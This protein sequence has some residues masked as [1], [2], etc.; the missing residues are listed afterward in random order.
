MK[1]WGQLVSSH[2]LSAEFVN[3]NANY[4]QI[5]LFAA[6]EPF[7]NAAASQFILGQQIPLPLWLSLAPVVLGKPFILLYFLAWS[8]SMWC[9]DSTQNISCKLLVRHV[10]I[11]PKEYF[12]YANE[13]SRTIFYIWS[14]FVTWI[15]IFNLNLLVISLI[16]ITPLNWYARCINGITNWA[17]FQLVG[18][19]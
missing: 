1:N 12:S 8:L 13:F 3:W 5:S 7:F 4:F 16:S 6:L 19:H 14:D 2:D 15:P 11:Y 17:F 18:I 10:S 9:A